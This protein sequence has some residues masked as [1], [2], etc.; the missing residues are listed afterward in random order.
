[1]KM[2]KKTAAAAVCTLVVF[3]LFCFFHYLSPFI[4]QTNDDLFLR[5]I[6]SGEM[7]GEAESR[8]HYIL[9]LIHI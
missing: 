7:S 3:L 2:N 8:L 6:A 5:M 1:M 4:Y 9:S